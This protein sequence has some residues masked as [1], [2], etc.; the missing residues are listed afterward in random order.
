MTHEEHN[1]SKNENRWKVSREIFANKSDFQRYVLIVSA[2]YWEQAPQWAAQPMGIHFSVPLLC[3][4]L[5]YHCDT[6]IPSHQ[7]ARKKG[8][9]CV[10]KKT[11]K[12]RR[13]NELGI[14]KCV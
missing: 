4:L 10:H 13:E 7:L 9:I 11:A 5:T 2:A 6:S 14:L 8:T 3:L 1:Q 12:D